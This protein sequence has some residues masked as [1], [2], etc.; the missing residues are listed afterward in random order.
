MSSLSHKHGP[1]EQHFGETPERQLPT[2]HA[3]MALTLGGWRSDVRIAI[4][5]GAIASVTPGVAA[6]VGDERHDVVLSA[7][8]NLHCHAFQR[9]MAGLA[10]RRGAGADSFWSWRETMYRFALTMTPDDLEAVA[11]QLYVEMLEAGFA[12]VAEFH[13]LHN[14][15]DGTPYASPAEMAGRIVAAARAAG[16]GLTLL[17]VFYAHSTFGGA[18]PK[19]EQRRFVTNIKNF[20]RL[21]DDC[22][23]YVEGGGETVG[24]APHSLRAVTPKELADVAAMAPDG[25]I[26][27]HVAEQMK[28]VEDCLAWSGK[29]PVRWLLDKAEVDERWCLVHATHMDAGE[30]RDAANSGAVV[31]LCPVTEAN[32]GDG[33]FDAPAFVG[34]GGRFG[35]GTDSNVSVGAADE[36]RQLEYSQRL[37]FKARNVMAPPGGSTGRTMLDAALRGGAQALAR[38]SGRLEAGAV[39]DLLTLSADHPAMY[40]KSGDD[41]LDAWIFCA[42]AGAVDCV[43]SAGH[44]VVSGGAHAERERI[45]ARFKRTLEKLSRL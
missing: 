21:V 16:V 27:I 18:A 10:E 4:D 13:Y 11:A 34:A 20:A 22:D 24:V 15:P 42:G 23:R 14:A 12:S 32:L 8:A 25:P 3:A 28:E 7:L 6:E 37:M 41:I 17:P 2:L 9:A 26:H 45:A 35:V 40:G 36:L 38:G 31:G 29:R 5:G 39:A 19:P 44:K 1:P 33:V 43:W 30:T